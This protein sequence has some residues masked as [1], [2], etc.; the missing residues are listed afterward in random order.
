[1]DP[2]HGQQLEHCPWLNKLP[3]H[4]RYSCGI[5][6]DRPGDCR[7]YPVTIEQMIE[8]GCEMLEACD[9]VNPKRA[10]KVLDELM[11]DSRPAYE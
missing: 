8:D 7:Y 9:L 6:F 4:N 3:G 11:A 5:Y 1:M 2:E 10:Q